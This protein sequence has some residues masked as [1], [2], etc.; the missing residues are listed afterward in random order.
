MM[1]TKHGDGKKACQ[2]F[3]ADLYGLREAKY[4]YLDQ[5]D[6]STT[7]WQPLHP[8]SE[9]YLLVPQDTRL[10]G[11]YEKYPKVTDIFPVNSVGIV[12]AR[13]DLTIKWSRDEVWETVQRFAS[14]E[15]ELA[16]AGYQ[17]GKDARDW[18]VELAQKDLLD[19]GPDKTNIQSILYRPFDIRYT[20]YTGHSRGFHCMPRRDVMQHMMKENIGLSCCR[21]LSSTEYHHAFVT[22]HIVDDSMVSNK[23]KE[24]GY[25]FPLYLEPESQAVLVKGQ[26]KLDLYGIQHTLRTHVDRQANIA[27]EFMASLVRT[28]N[29]SVMPEEIFYYIYAV[30][31]STVYRQKYADFL[32]RDFPRIPFTPDHALFLDLGKLGKRL[33]DLHLMKSTELEVPA[34]RFE[35][36]GGG[37][38]DEVRWEAGSVWINA[39]QH[40]TPVAADVWQY[41]V[42]GYQVCHKWLKDRKGRALRAEDIRHYC[43]VATALGRTVEIQRE[44]DGMPSSPSPTRLASEGG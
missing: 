15:P 38:V 1:S 8:Q 6:V 31:Y 42:G 39:T 20:Y 12:T 36:A 18:K 26:E 7:D 37:R 44:I 32:K 33:A 16:R 27:S 19:S 40:F 35:G 21:Q 5:H 3:Y 28:F 34:V 23:T 43:R 13:D 11:A 29:Q 17:L 41:Q 25:L 24:R 14:L 2:V 4:E 10:L 9:T 22:S 30:L